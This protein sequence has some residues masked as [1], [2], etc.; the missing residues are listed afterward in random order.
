MNNSELFFSFF[1]ESF[2]EVKNN[3]SKY[4]YIFISL[5]IFTNL[6]EGV[7]ALSGQDSEGGTIFV[8]LVSV[9][10]TFVISAKIILMHK[11]NASPKDSMLSIL[12]P[13]LLYSF[14][15]S[16]FF[17]AGLIFLILPGLWVLIYFSQLPFIAALSSTKE[18]YF[19]KSIKL[20]KKN[21]GLVAYI[22]IS[23]VV[24]EFFALIFT[25]IADAKLRFILTAIFSVPDALLSIV[26]TIVSVKIFYYL[27]E[28]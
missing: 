20:V 11:K 18:S 27:E 19:K 9:L 25:P 21:T 13:F 26:L 8:T 22:S 4:I 5:I 16:I 2:F 14:Y 15:Y 17:F 12:V 3:I 23:T 28:V 24:L 1:K 7:K 6:D 10:F